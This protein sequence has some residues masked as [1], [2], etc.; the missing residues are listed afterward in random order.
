MQPSMRSTLARLINFGAALCAAFGTAAA[1]QPTDADFL[2]AKGAFERNDVRT[3]DTLAPRFAGYVLEPYVTYWRLRV[4]LDA[5]DPQAVRAFLDRERDTPL[6]DR[7]RVDWLKLAGRRGDWNRFAIDYPPPNGEDTELAC[8]GV[9]YRR[10]RDGDAALAAARPYWFTGQSTP[11]AC[12]P[13]FEAL[14][15]RGDLTTADRRARFRLATEAG[16]PRLAMLVASGM[17]ANERIDAKDLAQVERDPLRAITRGEFRWRS[18]A[19]RDLALYAVERAARKDAAGARAAW[20]RW[21]VQVPVADRLYGDVRI[22]YYGARQLDPASNGWYREAAGAPMG[23]EQHAWR[24][25]AA[26][27]AQSWDDVLAAVDAMPPALAQDPPWRYWRARAL[28]AKGRAAEAKPIFETLAEE[29]HFYALLSAEALGTRIVPKS[30]PYAPTA[31]AF[32][33]FGSRPGVQ[34]AVKLAQLDLKSESLREWIYVVRSA[35]D[36]GLLLAAEY[37][38][39]AGMYDRAINTADRTTRRHDFSLRYLIPFRDQFA[40]A[41][42]ENGIDESVLLAI[43]RQESRFSPTI[44]SSAGAAGLMQLMPG[45]ARWV[46]KQVGRADFKTSMITDVDLNTRFGAF[47]FKYWL[48]R[49]DGR[50]ALAAAAYN[51]GPSRAQAWRPAT[52]VEGAIWVETIP[53][54]ETRDYV[55]KV[56]A[57]AMFYSQVLERPADT[58]TDRLATVKPR[59]EAADAAIAAGAP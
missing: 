48:D 44:V 39:R 47:Y 8:Y 24:V 23:D 33:A 43:A 9:Q 18:P 50:Q 42:R 7:L 28:A 37:A 57:N 1:A 52:P 21:R 45:T 16:N 55:K 41:A 51:A 54:N 49:L 35:D 15:A 40:A 32:A 25:R 17:P 36:E 12:E 14:F 34:R 38:R 11:D 3:L 58:L 22:A 13:L 46:A 6:G 27:R 20:V 29:F 30:D 4:S 26:L 2:A 5:A 56:M 53:F 31:E 19:G 59:G 10:Q